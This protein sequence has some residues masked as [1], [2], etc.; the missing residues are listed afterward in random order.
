MLIYQLKRYS[1]CVLFFLLLGISSLKSQ[2]FYYSKP[3][4]DLNLTTTWG[5]NTDGSGVQPLN[6]TLLN[7]VFIITNRTSATIGAAWTVSGLGSRVQLG[8]GSTNVEFIIPSGFAFTGTIDVTNSATLTNQNAANPTLGTLSAGS[9]VNYA[10]TVN[11]TVLSAAYYNLSLG[12]SGQKLMANTVSSSVSNLLDIA[13]GVSFRLHTSNTLSTTLSGSITGSGAILGNANSNLIIN[14]SGNFGTLTF[15]TTLSLYQLIINRAGNGTVT[16]G[17]NLTVSNAFTHS[18]GL[19][20]LNGRALTLNNAITF[21]P[22]ISNGAFIGSASSSLAIAASTATMTNAL[23]MSQSSSTSRTLNRFSYSR[24]GQTLVLGNSLIVVSNFVQSLGNIELNNQSLSIGGIIT[25]P[26][27]VANGVFIGST[28]STLIINGAGAITNTL[29]FDQTNAGTRSLHSFTVDHTGGTVTFGTSIN[30]VSNFVHNNGPIALGANLLSLDGNIT[31]PLTATNGSITGSATSSISIGGSGSI[32]N[33]LFMR[34]NNAAARTLNSFVLN[35]AGQTLALGSPLIVNTFNHLNGNLSLNGSLLTLNG[36]ITFP[37]TITNGAFIGSTTSSLI[38]GTSTSTITNSILF[39]QGSASTR[40][41]SQFSFNRT[42]QTLFLGNNLTIV[43][44]Y[45][46][47]N[48]NINLNG[49][50]LSINGVI[51]FPAAI[52][53]GAFVSTATSSLNI[54]GAGAITNTLKFDQTNATTRTLHSFTVDHTGG[55]V[56]LGNNITCSN[57]F[58]HVNGPIT[59]GTTSLTLDGN[60][61]FPVAATNGSFTGST[62]SSLSIGGSGSISNA[63]FMSQASAAARTLNNL[64]LNRSSQTLALGNA[65]IVNTYNQSNGSLNLNGNLITFNGAIT[66]PATLTNGAFI[67]SGTSS[68]VIATSASTI[69]NAIRMNQGTATSS[70]LSQFSFNRTTQTLVIGSNINITNNFVHTNG[71]IDLNGQLFSIGGIITFPVAITNGAFVSTA[72]SSL[73]IGGAGAIT[74]TLKFDQTNATTRTLHSFTVDH[75][76][77]TVSLGNNLTCSANFVHLNGPITLGTTSLSLDGNITFPVAATNGSFTGSATSSLSIGG[78]GSISNSIFMSQ[79]SAAARTFNSFSLNRVGQSLVLGN[80]LIT[81]DYTQT[82]GNVNIN[83][84]LLTLNG[85]IAF[86]SSISNGAFVGSLTSSLSIT[87]TGVITNALLMSQTNSTTRSLYDLLL[88]RTGQTLNIGNALEIRNSIT[89]T[90]G[91]ITTGGF[92]TLKSDAVR[93]AMVGVVGGAMTGNLNVESF[94]PGGFTGWT[95][96]GP[97]GVSGLTVANWENQM[98]MTCIS[99]PNNE[100]SA[101]GY[102]V[103]IQ[104]FSE[105]AT[106]TAA[107]VPMTY[108]SALTQ[109]RGYWVYMGTGQNT[110]SAITYSVTGPVVTG[111][112][113]VPLTRSAN[114]GFNL[115]SNPYPAPIDWDLVTAD[116]ANA[117]V[118]GSVYFYNPDL[119]VSI[120]YAA[121]VSNPSGYITNGVIP[122]GQGFYVQANTGTNLT[123]RETHKSTA[124]TNANPLLK[125]QQNDSVGTIFR[126][127]ITG[128]NLDYDETT[129]RFHN[130]ATKAFDNSLDAV[131]IF[132]TPGYV[133][134]TGLYSKYTTISSRLGNDDYAINS[135]PKQQT[136]PFSIPIL[137]KVMSTGTYVI[138]PVDL[139]NLPSTSCVMLKDKLLNVNHDLRNGAYTCQINDSTSVARFE[140]TIC[141]LTTEINTFQ[142]SGINKIKIGQTG[143][144]EITIYTEFEK[145]VNST[146]SVYNVLGQKVIEDIEINGA[147]SNTKLNLNHIE[148]QILIIKVS[149]ELGLES[150]KV[151][152]R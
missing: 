102:F 42:T 116:A 126:L 83:G 57:N 17:S 135:L 48:G 129:F 34:Q 123:F 38:I 28:T 138:A 8:D 81:N 152:L 133:G 53:N 91:S 3:I 124:N 12:G 88:N 122:M 136:E 61:T 60:I 67:G 147:A 27:S 74:N 75:T 103:S 79:A 92:V 141:E 20:D 63:I 105:A 49:Q 78:S 108:T 101:G 18:N 11:Q 86:P 106:G 44:S 52:A 4:G 6:F 115:V 73:N 128:S 50:L 26:T 70:V 143:S 29:K 1:F 82:N 58:V 93:S 114:T 15:T 134:T 24:T 54:G 21:P 142:L 72:T 23:L 2:V 140:L 110:T 120:S 77:G 94:A 16:L 71:R 96:L 80:P 41:L 104:S 47:T 132:Q 55:T 66:L 22:S 5:L 144:S 84:T 40:A 146:I 45:A 7:Q 85:V 19:F 100:Y 33:S 149:N 90:L 107:Y 131:K 43:N 59:I 69:T 87:G 118:S 95:N 51:A 13:S 137:V 112:V 111:N 150:K 10:G 130:L 99:C 121:G 145:E 62:T 119:A 36:A 89:P 151:Y 30:S 113:V 56:S 76:G 117:N 37:T 125:T 9:T 25:F 39:N 109:G 98:N 127:S 65:L 68:I 64:I 97:S 14:G 148:S 31:F 32:T 35:R 46:Q 139:Q